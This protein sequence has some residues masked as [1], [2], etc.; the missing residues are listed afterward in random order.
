MRKASLLL[1]ISLAALALPALAQ[2]DISFFITSKGPGKGAELGGLAGADQHCQSLAATAGAGG[3]IWHAYLSTSAAG[4]QA[5]INARD[6]IGRV[7]GVPT[8]VGASDGAYATKVGVNWDVIRGATAY[9]IFRNTVDDTASA[10]Q[11]GT[12]ASLIFFDATAVTEQ[13]YFYWVRARTGGLVSDF[14]ASDQGFRADGEI[15]GGFIRPKPLEPPR[16]PPEN[17]VTGAKVYLGK[18]LFWDEQLSSTRTVSCGTCHSPRAG[19][20][21]PRSGEAPELAMH[22]GPDDTF[23]TD[24]DAV[25]SRGVPMTLADGSYQSSEHF[26]FREQVTGRKALAVIEAAYATDLF[27]DGRARTQ[28]VDP[29][30]GSVVIQSGG[31][32][33][34]Q[35]LMP[36]TES[37]EMSHVGATLEN[38]IAR[39]AASKPL[40]LSPALPPA[41]ATWIGDSS[42]PQLFE[43]AFGTPEVTAPRIAMAIATYERTLYSDR[44]PF[45]LESADIQ[46]HPPAEQRGRNVF[47]KVTCNLC[48]QSGLTGDSFFR[49]LGVRPVE[50]DEGRFV[51][52]GA[53]R[54]LGAF[55]TPSLRNVGLRAPFMHNGRFST[56]EEVIEFYD[57]GG[58]FKGPHQNIQ[59]RR[60]NLRSDEKADL[61]TFLKNELTDQRVAT[62]S[63]PLFDRPM[64]YTESARVPR[65]ISGGTAGSG[66]FIPQVI[67]IEPPLA[68]NPSFTVALASALGG[69]QATLVIDAAD[70]GTGP[71]IPGTAVLARETVAVNGSGAGEGWASVSIAI[72]NDAGL[73]GSK[74]F[75]RW[76]VA[77]GGSAVGI[78]VSPLFEIT[79]FDGGL[80]GPEETLLT[81]VSAADFMIGPV[82]PESI[83]TGFA[84]DL[85]AFE[86]SAASM[87]LPTALGGITVVVRDSMGSERLARLFYCSPGQINYLIPAGTAPGEATVQVLRSGVV[88][89]SGTLQVAAVAPAL[90]TANSSG[91][92]IASALVLRI[93]ADGTQSYE[94]VARLEAGEKAF[95]AEPIDVGPESDRL[96]LI[97]FGTGFRYGSGLSGVTASVGGLDTDVL[98]AGPH[99]VFAGVDQ[100]NLPLDRALAGRGTVD[101][102]IAADG[103]AANKVQVHFAPPQ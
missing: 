55:R 4:G 72:P 67:A 32:L 83:V 51:V 28:F 101:V 42:Y 92:G 89:A 10:T 7:L 80:A 23:G 85:A 36:L 2:N 70:P 44:T 18:T 78:A 102:I 30:T 65:V 25:G 56:L 58:D 100:I 1:S 12:T 19:G 13:N 21:D 24:D 20:A 26:G 96:F 88:V 93:K 99:S 68:G 74:L 79:L 43:E 45:D 63:G 98:F 35:A 69:A 76:F 39:I 34:S 54:E 52:T 14:S 48:H 8:S 61:V 94:P 16:A 91:T 90:F 64:L 9:E 87:P 57:R 103:Q 71:M 81:S 29:V 84:A 62:E 3:K 97:L 50:E 27:W 73:I 5:A 59:M 46:D 41:L 33:E 82:A 47:I 6:R 15:P 66:G 31:G 49:N 40:A 86:E 22:P 60:L 75:G 53:A 95:V 11:V 37:V 77:D 17:P 38:V